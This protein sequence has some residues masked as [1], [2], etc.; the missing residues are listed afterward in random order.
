MAVSRMRFKKVNQELPQIIVI[1]MI[2]IMFFLLV[3]FML[4]TMYMTNLRTV[5]VKLSDLQGGAVAQEVAFAITVNDKGEMFVGETQV[6]LQTVQQYAQKEIDKDPNAVIV[7]RTDANSSYK[8]FS[9]LI[10]AL[11]TVG[12]ARFGIATDAGE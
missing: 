2:D 7:V 11:K 9:E 12:V 8:D 4:S 3:F 1:P 10:N 5:S 6:N